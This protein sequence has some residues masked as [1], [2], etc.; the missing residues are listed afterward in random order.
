MG[1]LLPA[2][3][4]TAGKT[5]RATDESADSPIGLLPQTGLSGQS[6]HPSSRPGPYR[7]SDEIEYSRK[8]VASSPVQMVLNR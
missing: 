4:F 5:A 2:R 7:L 8:Y 1:K 3:L 6:A